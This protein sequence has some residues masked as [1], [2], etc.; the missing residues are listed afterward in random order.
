ML[1]TEVQVGITAEETWWGMAVEDPRDTLM[2]TT[3]LEMKG[4]MKN[5]SIW[6]ELS[7]LRYQ[8]WPT[9]SRSRMLVQAVKRNKRSRDKNMNIYEEHNL[10]L[11]Q[12]YRKDKSKNKFQI[13]N[14]SNNPSINTFTKVRVINRILIKISGRITIHHREEIMRTATLLHKGSL[15]KEETQTIMTI[16]KITIINKK[17]NLWGLI[18]LRSLPTKMIRSLS[19]LYHLQFQLIKTSLITANSN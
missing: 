5:M 9:E 13:I 1:V 7:H 2:I 17:G 4:S 14:S 18:R 8:H 16:I 10:L 11:F 6:R 15:I 12:L 3:I 19:D